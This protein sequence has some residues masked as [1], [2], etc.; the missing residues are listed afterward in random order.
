MQLADHEVGVGDRER[1]AAPVAGRPRIGARRFGPD[2]EARA[3]EG[4]DRAA[5]GGHG[6][7]RHHRR[8]QA[9]ARDLGFEGPL[10]VAGVVRDVGRGAAHVE[11]DDAPESGEL[12]DAHAADDAAGRPGQDGVLALEQLR[13][14]QAA[15]RLHEHQPD[16]AERA[17]ELIDIAPEDGREIGVDHRGVAAARRASSAATPG[18]SPRPGRSRCR[19]RVRRAP[20]RGR[21]GGSRASARSRARGCHAP[22]RLQIGRWLARRSIGRSTVPSARTR[23]SI[24][25]TSAYSISGSTMCRAKMSG[26]CW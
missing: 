23:S 5:A 25:T 14:D 12:R 4:E 24:S 18:G 6:V 1:A 11:G 9:H 20:A 3:V 26:R 15:V 8:P 22:G 13:V 17:R 21:G 16:V 19:A 2:P 10:V 7:D